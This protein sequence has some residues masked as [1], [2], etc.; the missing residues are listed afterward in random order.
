MNTRCFHRFTWTVLITL[1]LSFAFTVRPQTPTECNDKGSIAGGP[2]V[3]PVDTSCTSTP[4]DVGVQGAWSGDPGQRVVCKD[5]LPSGSRFNKHHL[6]GLW[7]ETG[8]R[9]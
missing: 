7:K 9:V 8:N 6:H 1:L 5:C 4:T 3:N 2:V